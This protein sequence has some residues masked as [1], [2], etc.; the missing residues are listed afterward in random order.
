MLRRKPYWQ[1]TTPSTPIPVVSVPEPILQL[2]ML[3]TRGF[4]IVALQPVVAAVV[5]ITRTLPVEVLK[6]SWV[7]SV[8]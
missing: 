1:T 7:V 6:F 5:E 4:V 8:E 3:V 2:V